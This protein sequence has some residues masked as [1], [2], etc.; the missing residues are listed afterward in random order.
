[1]NNRQIG[2]LSSGGAILF[3]GLILPSVTHYLLKTEQ[4][5]TVLFMRIFWALILMIIVQII[6]GRLSNMFLFDIKSIA[7][8]GLAAMLSMS[9]WLIFIYSMQI[10]KLNDSSLGYFIMP[11]L[12][13]GLAYVFLGEKLDKLQMLAL[14]FAFLGVVWAVVING[15]LPLIALGVALTFGF[16]G[17]LKRK[18]EVNV[19]SGMLIEFMFMFVYAIVITLLLKKTDILFIFRPNLPENLGALAIGFCSV[20]PLLFFAVTVKKLEYTLVSVL[21]W[22]SPSLQFFLSLWVWRE[23]F[24]AQRLITFIFIWIGLA[25]YGYSLIKHYHKKRNMA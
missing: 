4:A 16:Y 5:P 11:V 21:Q 2:Y 24:D 13:I 20:T 15:Q 1:M 8:L 19:Y 17:L 6:R 3:W 12:N 10:G 25:F 18:V 7:I 22:I 23:D 14:F 9:N